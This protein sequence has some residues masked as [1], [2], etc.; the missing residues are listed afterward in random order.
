MANDYTDKK[1]YVEPDDLEMNKQENEE[2]M[3][4][5][6]DIGLKPEDIKDE[7]FR[8]EYEAYIKAREARNGK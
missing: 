8:K 4:N 5:M 6:Y 7:E 2:F 1:Y 3:E